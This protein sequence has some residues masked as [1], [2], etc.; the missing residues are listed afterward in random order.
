MPGDQPLW[1]RAVLRVERAVG[2]PVESAVRSEKYFDLVTKTTRI[3]RK[4]GGAAEGVS[5]RALHVLNLPAGSDIRRVR[6]QLAR[7]ERQIDQLAGD[8]AE[9]DESRTSDGSSRATGGSPRATGGSPRTTGRSA[10]AT[11]GSRSNSEV[12]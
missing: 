12:K 10:R 11:G 7:M 4:A 3:R 6:Q 2:K 8:V 9:I 5:R 1:L